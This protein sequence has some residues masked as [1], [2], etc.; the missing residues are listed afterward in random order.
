L[1]LVAA[2][3]VGAFVYAGSDT[4]AGRKSTATVVKEES[5]NSSNTSTVTTVKKADSQPVTSNSVASASPTPKPSSDDNVF[6][7]GDDAKPE[8]DGYEA[9]EV[10]VGLSPSVVVPGKT[11]EISVRGFHPNEPVTISIDPAPAVG[12]GRNDKAAVVPSTGLVIKTDPRGRGKIKI[13]VTQAPGRWIVTALGTV[14]D[15]SG[16]KRSSAAFLKVVLKK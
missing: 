12:G 3:G 7:V 5:A 9:R 14:T 16:A 4:S 6:H 10:F 11:I 8:L 15:S 2:I 13:P 1:L